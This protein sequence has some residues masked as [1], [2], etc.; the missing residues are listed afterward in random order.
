MKNRG[1]TLL[2][3]IVVCVL[4][5]IMLVVS[6]PTLR[7][8]FVDDSLKATSRKIIGFVGGV[9]ELAAREQQPYY[10]Y[11]DRAEALLW[12]EKDMPGDVR[13][14]KDAKEER[15]ELNISAGVKISEIWTESEGIYA[16]DQ[17]RIWISPKGY[18]DQTVLH[19]AEGD[20]VISLHFFPFLHDVRIYDEYTPAR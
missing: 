16:D 19:L 6:V 5:G 15:Q 2:E 7:N 13:E 11:F 18:M 4:I 12:Y 10:L 14:R 9:R 1:F 3:L 8:A 17:N 20:R